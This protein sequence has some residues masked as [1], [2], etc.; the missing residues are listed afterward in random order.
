LLFLSEDQP[1][2]DRV[3]AMKIERPTIV[4][5]AAEVQDIIGRY[6]D[7]GVDELIVPGFTFR[8]AGEREEALGRFL[9]VSAA[10]FR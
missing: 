5:T 2:L 6:R 10:P 9:T 7:A 4:G 3:R 8:S 1:V